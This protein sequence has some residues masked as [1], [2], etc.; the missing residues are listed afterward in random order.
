MLLILASFKEKGIQIRRC[1]DPLG[2]ILGVNTH[3]EDFYFSL[4]YFFFFFFS[5]IKRFRGKQNKN[6][7]A[8]ESTKA[9]TFDSGHLFF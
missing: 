3:R 4:L 8:A 9:L 7:S 1:K 2:I 6:L 5:S